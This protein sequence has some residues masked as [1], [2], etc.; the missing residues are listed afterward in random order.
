MQNVQNAT[1]TAVKH[2]T[3]IT[4]LSDAGS[5]ATHQFFLNLG[6][7]VTQVWEYFNLKKLSFNRGGTFRM[8]LIEVSA[9]SSGDPIPN[10]VGYYVY[11]GYFQPTSVGSNPSTDPNSFL[12]G[13]LNSLVIRAGGGD[14]FTPISIDRLNAV[15]TTSAGVWSNWIYSATKQGAIDLWLDSLPAQSN[16]DLRLGKTYSNP[17][18]GG[19]T[20]EVIY[21]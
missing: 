4:Q 17:N 16:S 12:Y 6:I 5:S 15:T 2:Y 7:N 13:D 11:S 18:N 20:Y 9:P 10:T 3:I 19:F 21:N 1:N 8:V 14:D